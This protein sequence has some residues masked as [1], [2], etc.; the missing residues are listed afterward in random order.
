MHL[1]CRSLLLSVFCSMLLLASAPQSWAQESVC[2]TQNRS[3]KPGLV[4]WHKSFD[5]ACLAAKSSGKPVLLFQMLG[6]LDQE[7]C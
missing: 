1:L 2:S 3:I 6:R 5:E 4:R 7:F